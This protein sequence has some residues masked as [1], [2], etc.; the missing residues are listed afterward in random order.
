MTST[1]GRRYHHGDLRSAIVAESL[2]VLGE[3]GLVGFSL[4][5]VARRIGVSPASPYRHFADRDEVLAAVAERVAVELR[6]CLQAAVDGAGADPAERFAAMVGAYTGYVMSHRVGLDLVYLE[7]LRDAR[8]AELHSR[9][10]DLRVLRLVLAK[11]A[12]P[13]ADGRQAVELLMQTTALAHGYAELHIHSEHTS[14]RPNH[15]RIR[16]SAETAARIL[17][18]GH[19]QRQAADARG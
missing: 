12:L 3:D 10:R 2:S 8:Y 5:K 9:A 15:E 18:A 14:R 11:Q 16:G 6:E 13:E 7:P 19:R 17:V 4:A 1:G